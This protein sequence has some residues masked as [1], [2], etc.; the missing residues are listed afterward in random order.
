MSE[1]MWIGILILSPFVGFL[2]NGAYFKNKNVKLAGAIASAAMLISFYS[3]C[4]L[5][6]KL[7][8]LPIAEREISHRVFSRSDFRNNDFDYY[9]CR[10]IDTY[11]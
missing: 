10:L 3:A 11:F 8:N 7:T 1:S 4:I 2:L 5:F 9:W 6:T